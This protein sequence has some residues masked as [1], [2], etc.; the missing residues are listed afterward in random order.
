MALRER[1]VVKGWLVEGLSAGRGVLVVRPGYVCFIPTERMTSLV[2][3]LAKGLA[4]AATGVAVIP[5]GKGKAPSPAELVR[6]LE[7][8]PADELDDMLLGG[9][10]STGLVVWRPGDAEVVSKRPLLRRKRGLW[11]VSGRASLRCAR[12]FDAAEQGELKRLL[13]QWQSAP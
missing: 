5:L 2:G 7:S 4:A 9:Q 1:L 13:S 6:Y 10:A 3:E 11:F 12:L 8:L